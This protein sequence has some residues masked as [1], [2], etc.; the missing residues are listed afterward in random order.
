D[1][2]VLIRGGEVFAAGLPEEVL[3]EE[4]LERVYGVKCSVT[5]SFLGVPQVTPLS[6]GHG[7]LKKPPNVTLPHK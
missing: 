2:M 7:G 1:V 5:R 6:D 4:N 3:T